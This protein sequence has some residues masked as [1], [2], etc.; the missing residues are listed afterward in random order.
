MA[1][2]VK[3]LVVTFEADLGAEGAET[4]AKAIACL[5]GVVGVE[6]VESD[7]DDQ[8][9]RTQIRSEIGQQLLAVLYPRAQ[10]ARESP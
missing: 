6:A 7:F 10:G 4:L 3:G 1:N 9:N 8:I 5:R 2:R